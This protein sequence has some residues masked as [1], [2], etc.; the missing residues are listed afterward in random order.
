MGHAP[1]IPIH[2]TLPLDSTPPAP[3]DEAPAAPTAAQRRPLPGGTELTAL[4]LAARGGAAEALERLIAETRHDVTRYIAGLADPSAVEDLTQETYIRVL[5]ALPRFAARSSA[6]TWL[7]AIARRVVVDRYRYLAARP[8]TTALPEWGEA[9]GR[10]GRFDEQ[11]ALADLLARL[12]AE[13]RT[14]F[15]LTQLHGYS[16]DEV[17]AMTTVPV[18]TVR[19]RVARARAELLRA[20]RDVEARV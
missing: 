16:Y 7:L 12:G 3:P 20:L 10:P 2:D 14:A 4:A 17:A 19:S 1:H 9:G 5:R 6:R 18:G 15:V 11:H 13:R 8:R